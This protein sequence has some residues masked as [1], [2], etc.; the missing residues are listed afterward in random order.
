MEYLNIASA[1]FAVGAAVLWLLS[2]KV[3][4]PNQF[5][6][7]VISVHEMVDQI[8]GAQVIST[9]SSPEIDDL[10]RALIRQSKLS[11][12]AAVCAGIAATCQA[13]VLISALIK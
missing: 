3:R 9:G 8:I 4:L 1:L 13:I 2:A 5:P 11:S 12:A 6:I 7:T 10:G